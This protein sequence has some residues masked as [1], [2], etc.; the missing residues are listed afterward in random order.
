VNFAPNLLIKHGAKLVTC[1]EDVIEE[2]P[3]PVR[4]ELTQLEQPEAERRNPLVAASLTGSGQKIY[5]LLSSGVARPIDDTVER[6]GP[7]S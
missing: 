7:N 5:A 1:A 2:L 6:T 4:A 3:K